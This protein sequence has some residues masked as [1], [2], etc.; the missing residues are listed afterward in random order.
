MYKKSQYNYFYKRKD[1]S[2]GVCN[3]FKGSIA[4]LSADE[5]KQYDALPEIINDS[6]EF[7]Q[8]LYKLG[9]LIDD[10]QDELALIN[11]CRFSKTYMRKDAYFRIL[12]TTDCNAR[13]EYCYESGISHET[14]S[15]DIAHEVADYI[16][17]HKGLEKIYIHWFGGEPLLNT[18]PIDI[19]MKELNSRISSQT[20]IYTYF[21]S[22]CSL[23]NSSLVQK[24][25]E[26]NTTW[27]Q[28]SLDGIGDRY[29]QIKA[30][31][32]T[33]RFNFNNTID[34]IELLLEQGIVVNLCI[35]Y[36]SKDIDSVYETIDYLKPRFQKYAKKG[37]LKISPSPLF[38]VPE[39][40]DRTEGIRHTPNTNLIKAKQYLENAGMTDGKDLFDISFK[41]GQCY[42]CTEGSVVISPTG[43]L[44]KCALA[45]KDS[46]MCIGDIF[47]G[48][49]HNANYFKWVTPIIPKECIDCIFLPLCQGG[50]RAGYFG[51]AEF[52]CYRTEYDFDSV[53]EYKIQRMLQ[54]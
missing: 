36:W 45:M 33:K 19:I 13:C 20:K 44:F 11:A 51:Y 18:R 39:I 38:V 41:E 29:N 22:N 15:D 4:I 17:K 26:W 34:N 48:I 5:K 25:V 12:T 35:K 43:K 40:Q 28:V 21:T 50:C 32:D 27:F 42:A 2:Y 6:N 1:S 14:M 23:L 52:G 10:D 31:R 54:K 7:I 16:C 24:L 46:S 9:M 3:T 47:N 8:E 49:R 30:Y 37:L 53:I